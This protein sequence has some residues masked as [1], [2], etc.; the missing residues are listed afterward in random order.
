M[1]KGKHV[2][3]KI[4]KVILLIRKHTPSVERAL[5][6]IQISGLV[7]NADKVR[8]LEVEGS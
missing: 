6:F 3:M 7:L 4:E 2:G 1:G 5:I 8:F